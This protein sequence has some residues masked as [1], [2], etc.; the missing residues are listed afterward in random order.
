ML[1]LCIYYV[2]M[3]IHYKVIIYYTEW[4]FTLAVDKTNE[5]NAPVASAASGTCTRIIISDGGKGGVG[6]SMIASA[7]TD[8]LLV[9]GKK[10]ALIEADTQNPDVS[11]MFGGDLQRIDADLRSVNGWMSVMDFIADHPGFDIVINTPAGIG[12]HFKQNISRLSDFL[13]TLEVPTEMDL[14]WTLGLLPDSVNLLNVAY[15]SYG[16]YFNNIRVVRNLY[17]SQ[18]LKNEGAFI[19]WDESPLKTK[20]EKLG[21]M[22]LNFPPI[23][24]RVLGKLINPENVMPFSHACDASN[25]EALGLSHSERYSLNAWFKDMC[26]VLA[27]ALVR[28]AAK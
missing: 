21:G 3:Y 12:D 26:A 19:F 23:T 8:Y 2:L 1:S 28:S 24:T 15:D 16:K 20:L 25:G 5:V 17:N 7:I 10:V 6:K 9:S 22:T 4:S 14:W 11:R 18:T 27:P 13:K